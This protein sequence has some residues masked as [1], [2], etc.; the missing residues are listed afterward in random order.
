MADVIGFSLFD[1]IQANHVPRASVPH[2]PE[3][4]SSERRAALGMG[5]NV[6][7][8]SQNWVISDIF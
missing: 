2:D 6:N 7:L 5:M 8:P 4:A 3:P 1:F